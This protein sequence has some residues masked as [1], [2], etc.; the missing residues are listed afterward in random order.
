MA[1]YKET[2]VIME[3]TIEELSSFKKFDRFIRLCT[4]YHVNRCENDD[5]E[6]C[7]FVKKLCHIYH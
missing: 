1:E 2:A 6:N 5:C 3:K 4:Y 7:T